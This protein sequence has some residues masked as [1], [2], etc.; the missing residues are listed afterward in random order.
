VVT[1]PNPVPAIT[2]W[3]SDRAG[4]FQFSLIHTYTDRYQHTDGRSVWL[5]EGVNY[6][7]K[8]LNISRSASKRSASVT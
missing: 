4:D 6:A 7:G 5:E 3:H 2:D 1:G 8:V